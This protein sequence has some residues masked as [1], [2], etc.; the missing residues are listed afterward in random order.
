MLYVFKKYK[1]IHDHM[2]SKQPIA[3]ANRSTSILGL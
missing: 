1:H 2:Y 3:K